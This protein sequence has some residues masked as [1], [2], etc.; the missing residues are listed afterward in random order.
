[1]KFL[2]RSRSTVGAMLHQRALLLL[3][4]LH[5]YKSHRRLR[6]G[7]IS[8][9]SR[10]TRAPSN[11]A[12]AQASMPTRHGASASKKAITW[13]RARSAIVSPREGLKR[14]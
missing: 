3:S 10:V 4:R 11:V 6:V 8:W 13:R 1:M 2:S 7:G 5:L 14:V 12:E 9:P